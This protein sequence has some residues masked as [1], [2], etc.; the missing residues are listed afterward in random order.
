MAVSPG[1]AQLYKRNCQ[2]A[3]GIWSQ[4][5]YPAQLTRTLSKSQ[6]VYSKLNLRISHA[7]LCQLYYSSRLGRGYLDN[8]DLGKLHFFTFEFNLECFFSF[9][10][11]S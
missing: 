9:S 8:R 2:D 1:T 3:I 11:V 6:I 5:N 10:L 4:A 7:L